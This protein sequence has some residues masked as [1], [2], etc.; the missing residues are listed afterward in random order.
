MWKFWLIA[1]GIF[2]V[3]E[4]FTT[5]FLIFWFG[6]GA[7]L[8]MIASLFITNIFIQATIFVISS[9]LLIF[10]TK[11]LINKF[12]S[13]KTV[14]TNVY[15]VIGKK[16]IVTQEINPITGKGQVK[17]GNEIWTAISDETLPLDTHIEVLKVEGVKLIVKSSSEAKQKA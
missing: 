3:G 10:L 5:G 15:E 7:L 2:F 14:A 12:V 16:G 6:L 9:T 4:I 11:P 17:V 13:K 8:T 1:S